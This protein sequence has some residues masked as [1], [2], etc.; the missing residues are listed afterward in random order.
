M[1]K[2]IIVYFLNSIIRYYTQNE[3]KTNNTIVPIINFTLGW[4]IG[5]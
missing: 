5:K 1:L 2:Q 3:S 4:V